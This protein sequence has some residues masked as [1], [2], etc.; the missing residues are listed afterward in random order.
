MSAPTHEQRIEQLN[1]VFE[2]LKPFLAENKLEAVLI[3]RDPSLPSDN[4]STV[5]NMDNANVVGLYVQ[6]ALYAY[7]GMMNDVR[8]IMAQMEAGLNTK[9]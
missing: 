7:N 4:I 5:R 1:A 8:T 3:I 6:L 9:Q 2:L